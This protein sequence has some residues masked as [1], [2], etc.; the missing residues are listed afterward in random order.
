MKKFIAVILLVLMTI[1]PIYGA[2]GFAVTIGVATN[3]NDQWKSS[4]MDYF[5]SHI[6]KNVSTATTK[7]ITASEVNEISQ[8]ITGRT[9]SSNQIY[10]CAMVD[11]SYN[12]GINVTVD[13]SKINVVTPKM[14]A[15]AL[16]SLGIQ[17][18]YVV[19]TSPIQASGESALAGVLKSYEVAVGAQIPDSA[20]QVATDTL[21]TETSIAN[22]TGQSPDTIANLFEQV[23]N[24]VQKQ[25]LQDPSQIKVIV[26]NIANNLNINIS[27]SQAQQ[28]ANTISNSQKVQGDLAGFKSQLQNVTDQL[29]QSGGILG[30]I[31]SYIQS[32]FDYL[33]SLIFGQQ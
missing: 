33:K 29:S 11:L 26:I 12:N 18:G 13:S 1:S 4:V 21:Y 27:D 16:K 23:Q 6:D 19:V 10:S 28:I 20:K 24:E 30:Q 17:N 9:Y 3:S 7:L 14:Y 22:Q 25:N 32:A 8:N 5:Q 31:M 2:S 15:N